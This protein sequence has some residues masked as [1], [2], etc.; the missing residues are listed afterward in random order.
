MW[1]KSIL[2]IYYFISIS[3][4]PALL[5][6]GP[7]ASYKVKNLSLVNTR[8]VYS[9][10]HKI[11]TSMGEVGQKSLI[12]YVQ[13]GKA[14]V[15]VAH[16]TLISNQYDKIK[17]QEK[18]E[19][20][21]LKKNWT[22][23][24]FPDLKWQI[25]ESTDFLMMESYWLKTNRYI[26]IYVQKT[27]SGSL[28]IVTMSRVGYLK[29]LYT[30]L[31]DVRNALIAGAKKQN[32][33]VSS[34]G[35][36]WKSNFLEI[37]FE[38]AF[39]Q[40][41]PN[42]N[43]LA[44][45]LGQANSAL[46]GAVS[47]GGAGIGAGAGGA[48][49]NVNLHITGGTANTVF[50]DATDNGVKVSDNSVLISNNAV[51]VSE[52]AV[53]TSGNLVTATGNTVT[54]SQN[55]LETSKTLAGA[56]N[57]AVDTLNSLA[58]DKNNAFQMSAAVAAGAVVGA[59]AANLVISGIATGASYLWNEV[60]FDK[61]NK[62]IRWD[63]FNDARMHLEKTENKALDIEK[64]L[65]ALELAISDMNKHEKS[66]AEKYKENSSD[67][68]GDF[69][70]FLSNVQKNEEK[71]ARVEGILATQQSDRASISSCIEKA[72]IHEETAK[73]IDAALK[74]ARENNIT[75]SNKNDFFC[76][77]LENIKRVAMETEIILADY[78]SKLVAGKLEYFN[79]REK[80]IEHRFK[81]SQ[82][83]NKQNSNGN[84]LEADKNLTD[85]AINYAQKLKKEEK[86]NFSA[87]CRSGLGDV[88]R[89]VHEKYKKEVEKNIHPYADSGIDKYTY[90]HFECLTVYNLIE[91]EKTKTGQNVDFEKIKKQAYEK[92]E[93]T[94]HTAANRLHGLNVERLEEDLNEK[95]RW[96][97]K[98][99][100][101]NQCYQY[102]GKM[103]PLQEKS[104]HQIAP[105]LMALYRSNKK[106]EKL[107]AENNCQ[108]SYEI[109]T[110]RVGPVDTNSILA[111]LS[112][113]HPQ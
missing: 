57:H 102:L 65:D 70:G 68:Y 75:F 30:D 60:L 51:I 19:L 63:R 72:N 16:M 59:L 4:H 52:N 31:Q 90:L 111:K 15:P 112:R 1:I 40:I 6:A 77:Q 49:V 13:L 53:V 101:E 26:N 41:N 89:F 66:Y 50:I 28:S 42:P 62:S 78:N 71:N 108:K 97:E 69:L 56:S 61:T 21:E 94:A 92:A 64:Q 74:F 58:R 27:N 81:E 24:A 73:N 54:A 38:K 33:K 79:F 88:G 37:F 84:F 46:T 95:R 11:K 110:A 17:D 99:E 8:W 85:E 87:Q 20:S 45:L 9:A 113:Q 10:F 105:E 106:V 48:P 43:D 107:L 32:K 96:F 3:L 80:E 93:Q 36:L 12:R 109:A 104:C 55:T 7:T 25:Q 103:S 34:R 86:N 35:F 76:K 98:K 44:G 100:S 14:L 91:E 67:G 47:G 29:H 18:N 82:F 23:K 22:E 5:Q 39:A 83:I 2:A